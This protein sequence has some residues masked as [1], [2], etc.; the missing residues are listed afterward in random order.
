MSRKRPVKTITA[1]THCWI[2]K[3][4]PKIS[5]EQRTVKNFRQVVKIETVRGPKCLIVVKIANWP[6]A[7]HMKN[8]HNL[9]VKKYKIKWFVF[10]QNKG[11][12]GIILGCFCIKISAL[13]P[14]DVKIRAGNKIMKEQ[15]LVQSIIFDGEGEN[16]LRI[17]SCIPPQR[18]SNN[19]DINNSTYPTPSW[20][21]LILRF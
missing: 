5:T 13:I 11:Y 9:K 16:E 19:K 12:L 8:A 20:N 4:F 14:S 21:F 10:F 3:I 2:V 1:P 18:P 15:K 6:N 7:E 17:F